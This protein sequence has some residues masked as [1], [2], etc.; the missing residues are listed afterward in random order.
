MKYHPI[1]GD[2]DPLT[3]DILKKIKPRG[4]WLDLAAGDGRYVPEL[5][6]TVER[7]VALDIN[8]ESLEKIQSLV[9]KKDSNRFQTVIGDFTAP[10]PFSKQY[11]DG[12]FCTGTLHC[13]PLPTVKKVFGYMDAI[14]KPGGTI[15]LDFATDIVRDFE[16]REKTHAKKTKTL[17]SSYVGPGYTKQEAKKFL[18]GLFMGYEVTMHQSTFKDDVRRVPGYGFKAKGRYWLVVGIKPE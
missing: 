11:F 17:P 13:F 14:L 1:W 10:L 7:L 3:L 4:V 9:K 6:S 16:A 12:V 5:L 15:I 2:G 18:D 8:K